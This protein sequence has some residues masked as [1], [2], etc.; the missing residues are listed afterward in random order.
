MKCKHSF[1][2]NAKVCKT[3]CE[4]SVDNLWI[5]KESFWKNVWFD[6]QIDN[7]KS[8]KQKYRFTTKW[9]PD[10]P[11]SFRIHMNESVFEPLQQPIVDPAN[12]CIF[13]YAIKK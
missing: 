2:I 13:F 7:I 6:I 4:L 8:D 12:D 10:F 1:H 9:I 11:N 3:I 5:T